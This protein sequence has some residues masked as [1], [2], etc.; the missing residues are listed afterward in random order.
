MGPKGINHAR[1]HARGEKPPQRPRRPDKKKV[2]QF[3]HIPF[4]IHK[5]VHRPQSIHQTPAQGRV[6]AI[7]KPRQRNTEGGNLQR[8]P[9]HP[10]GHVVGGLDN[11]MGLGYGQRALPE[12][13]AI[14]ANKGLV[15]HITGPYGPQR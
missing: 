10:R 5:P 1:I 15:P 9:L 2:I 14:M 8:K 6:I 4:V 3:I 7:K 13:L 11:V 12:C